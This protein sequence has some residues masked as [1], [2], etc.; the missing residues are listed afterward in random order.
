VE[1]LKRKHPSVAYNPDIA[2][3]FF[4]AGLIEA[5]GQGTI[6]IINECRKAGIT[7]PEFSYDLSGF[8]IEFKGKTIETSE[9]VSEKTSEKTS[10]KIIKFIKSNSQITIQELVSLIGISNRSIERNL[11]KLQKE[12]KLERVGPDKGGYWKVID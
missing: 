4:R 10:E 1:R 9:K 11:Q 12:N 3:T 8:M 7:E 2:T 5:W 6:K